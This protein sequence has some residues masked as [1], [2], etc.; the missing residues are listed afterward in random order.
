M[1][2]AEMNVSDKAE[3][4]L[5]ANFTEIARFEVSGAS[6]KPIAQAGY[7]PPLSQN[8]P[9]PFNSQT[10]ISYFL[11]RSGP[12]RLEVWALN[13]QRVAVLREGKAD[14]GPHRLVWDGLDR[15]GRSVASGVY[16]YRL[17]TDQG[18]F[19]QKLTLIR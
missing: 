7:G 8:W 6:A 17:I 5:R 15:Q 12:M 16:L 19:T 13:G 14:A 9:N 1:G 4:V 3:N 2:L 10:T 18:V 11:N